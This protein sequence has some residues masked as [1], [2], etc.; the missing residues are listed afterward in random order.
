MERIKIIK[1]IG[2]HKDR[3]QS[4]FLAQQKNQDNT[5]KLVILKAWQCE[6]K[7][8]HLLVK[9]DQCKQ[10]KKLKHDHIPEFSFYKM[11]QGLILI[12]PYQEAKTLSEILQLSHQ[13]IYSYN[14]A[15][16]ITNLITQLLPTLAYLTKQGIAHGNINP[17]HIL[18]D[19]AYNVYLIGFGFSCLQD[20]ESYLLNSPNSYQLFVKDYSDLYGFGLSLISFLVQ[21][22]DITDFIDLK[23]NR[24]NFGKHI[25]IPG[26]SR[27]LITWLR[28]LTHPRIEK[29][30][31]DANTALTEFNKIKAIC[32]PNPYK[33]RICLFSKPLVALSFCAAVFLGSMHHDQLWLS[34]QSR[35]IWG[36]RMEALDQELSQYL[37][38]KDSKIQQIEA[39]IEQYKTGVELSSSNLEKFQEDETEYIKSNFYTVF[40]EIKEQR[41]VELADW[42]SQSQSSFRDDINRKVNEL[43]KLSD[44]DL[45]DQLVLKE[46]N[47]MVGYPKKCLWIIPEFICRG[48]R[49]QW[50]RELET[51]PEL[52]SQVIDELEERKNQIQTE[53]ESLESLLLQEK[54]QI[55]AEINHQFN[56]RLVAL[57][58]VILEQKKEKTSE[59]SAQRPKLSTIIVETH[60]QFATPAKIW[61][62][63]GVV[64][65]A[66]V[67]VSVGAVSFIFL[68]NWNRGKRY[69]YLAIAAI[70][71]MIVTAG[72]TVLVDVSFIQ[73]LVIGVGIPA[74]LVGTNTGLCLVFTSNMANQLFQE[75]KLMKEYK[76]K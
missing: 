43:Q 59:I 14:F 55:Q 68:I 10:L 16:V 17:D 32:L 61:K 13:E 51:N 24:I 7:D 76:A 52:R 8:S 74:F 4:T 44:D 21:K 47:R 12:R 22:D 18:I 60:H 9:V 30:F 54:E 3:Q 2:L 57:K 37:I 67:G 31:Q 39:E 62:F 65:G 70:G 36:E 58:P 45:I 5:S 71:T 48:E 63:V 33:K 28:K 34:H 73:V 75:Y 11:K 6:P 42:E 56:R 66:T 29:R 20:Q 15:Q 72:V 53:V 49:N 27:E 40:D 69:Q 23:T 50:R 35:F 64:I 25:K 1:K 19:E 41:N 26:I 38:Q 46:V